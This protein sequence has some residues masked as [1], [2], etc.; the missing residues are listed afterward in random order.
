MDTTEF[1]DLTRKQKSKKTTGDM[2]GPSI[3]ITSL[4]D[5][6][7]DIRLPRSVADIKDK[8]GNTKNEV[9]NFQRFINIGYI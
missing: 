5:K 9:K 3:Q 2:T 1:N 7:I 4:N 8:I 6:D